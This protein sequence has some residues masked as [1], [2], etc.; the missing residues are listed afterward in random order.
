MDFYPCNTWISGHM[1]DSEPVP[2]ITQYEQ[3]SLNINKAKNS[4]CSKH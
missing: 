2:E 3:F 1:S 4:K